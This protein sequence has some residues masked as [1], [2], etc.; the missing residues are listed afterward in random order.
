MDIIGKVPQRPDYHAEGPVGVHT[1]MVRG[2]LE[3]AIKLM[4]QSAGDPDSPLSNLDLNFSKEDVNIL[5]LAAWLHDL[6]KASSTNIGGVHWKDAPGGD[7]TQ[8]RAPEHQMQYHFNPMARELLHS[9]MW[10][11]MYDNTSMEDKKTLWFVIRNH[12]DIS[13]TGFGKE[14]NRRLMGPDG[15]Y[16]NSR[17]V[18]LLLTLI[19]MDR[20]G[21]IGSSEEAKFS[22]P[23]DYL[24]TLGKNA[25]K[26]K[27]RLEKMAQK[28]S[29]PVSSDPVLFLRTVGDNL[30]KSAVKKGYK[31][32]AQYNFIRTQLIISLQQKSRK[33][34]LGLTDDAIRSYVDGYLNS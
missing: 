24:A 31:G 9:P 34:G 22:G 33:E 8:A 13:K 17:R 1:R 23:E 21:R 32:D 19:L 27:A 10:K 29:E 5:R 26:H 12:M 20:M 3:P 11:K 14:L 2:K 4:Q 7:I 25:A 6:G 15:K 30:R 16:K 18:K 28:Q